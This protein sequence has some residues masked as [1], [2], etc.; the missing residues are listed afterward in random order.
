MDP[1]T[2]KAAESCFGTNVKLGNVLR[3]VFGVS[4]QLMLEALLQGQA[5]PEEIARSWRRVVR[6]RRFG[7][8]SQPWRGIR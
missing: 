2:R 3:N 6:K 1:R 5:K 4:G 7:T 8:S